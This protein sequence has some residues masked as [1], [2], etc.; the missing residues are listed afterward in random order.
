MQNNLIKVK[1]ISSRDIEVGAELVI[2]LQTPALTF[3]DEGHIGY[4]TSLVVCPVTKITPVDEDNI[5]LT[6]KNLT[7]NET[8]HEVIKLTDDAAYMIVDL[9][10][11]L[12]EIETKEVKDNSKP[13]KTKT[14]DK[15]DTRKVMLG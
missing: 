15:E 10:E 14:K 1:A 8:T 2:S 13:V 7:N 11:Q 6:I 4:T 12:K 3:I 9:E 5:V